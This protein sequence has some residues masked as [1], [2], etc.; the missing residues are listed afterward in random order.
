MRKALLTAAGAAVLL[1]GTAL[2]P[3][4]AVLQLSV[5]IN[6]SVF[7]C[8]DN[9]ACDTNPTVGILQTGNQ[10]FNG[11]TFMG[12][13]QT[14]LTGLTNELTS[15]SFQITNNNA[16]AITYQLAVGG[17]SFVGPVTTIH[18]SGSGTWT[19]AIGSTITQVFHAD[20][21]NAQ[22]AGTPT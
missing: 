7:S 14:Q 20:A 15:T 17:T 21:T 6:G 8:V 4:H 5:D 18:N 2:T 3:A 16:G 1:G 10:T 9:T 11:V 22:G 13:S 19:N 12:S